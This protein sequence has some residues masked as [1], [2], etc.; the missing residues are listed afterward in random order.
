MWNLR[1]L[2]LKQPYGLQANLTIGTLLRGLVGLPRLKELCLHNVIHRGHN[3]NHRL[4]WPDV[5]LDELEWLRLEGETSDTLY[6]L[7]HIIFPASAS[8]SINVYHLGCT[9]YDVHSLSRVFAPGAPEASP[10]AHI[11]LRSLL[12]VMDATTF[13]LY[14][15]PHNQLMPRLSQITSL[16]DGRS[17]WL[18]GNM[19]SFPSRILG[20]ITG[21]TMLAEVEALSVNNRNG[22]NDIGM[23]CGVLRSMPKLRMLQLTGMGALSVL[24]SFL[25][26]INVE[27]FIRSPGT[28]IIVPNLETLILDRMPL[29]DARVF[30]HVRN[31]LDLQQNFRTNSYCSKPIAR[32][33]LV[34]C[35][36]L[37][38]EYSEIL[39]NLFAEVS[40]EATV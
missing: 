22:C 20:T 35:P 12:I 38:Q 17:F 31:H 37:P 30:T 27:T 34:R 7:P 29:D 26:S 11:A 36:V 32:L 16:R 14:A 33:Q 8:L 40:V 2:T 9:E 5:R 10:Q 39:C 24:W 6:C 23:W 1:S 4:H 19:L 13:S 28:D 21:T 15:A 18:C 3:P 25:T